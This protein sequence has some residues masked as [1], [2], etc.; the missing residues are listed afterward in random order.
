MD[1]KES[2]DIHLS[3]VPHKRSE[4]LVGPTSCTFDY[5]NSDVNEYFNG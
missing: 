1:P 4:I 3:F 2:A 5:G